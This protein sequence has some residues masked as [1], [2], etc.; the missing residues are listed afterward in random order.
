MTAGSE[1]ANAFDPWLASVAANSTAVQ[2]IID[3]AKGV[4]GNN[5]AAWAWGGK[6]AMDSNMEEWAKMVRLPS[7]CL[8]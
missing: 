2:T 6:M 7:V 1:A 8:G 5:S 3:Q 4:V